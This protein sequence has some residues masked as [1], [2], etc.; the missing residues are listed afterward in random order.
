MTPVVV[1]PQLRT[2]PARIGRHARRSSEH[3]QRQ[4]ATGLFLMVALI[5][6]GRHAVGIHGRRVAG[7]HDAIFKRQVFDLQWLKQ[8]I[9]FHQT[10]LLR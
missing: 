10:T 1:K 9:V 3:C 4:P 6:F 7:T 5:R 2:D 8:W